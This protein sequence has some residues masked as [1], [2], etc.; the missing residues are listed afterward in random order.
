MVR[1]TIYGNTRDV[2]HYMVI[3]TIYGN[4][5]IYGSITISVETYQTDSMDY[6]V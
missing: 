5:T 4:S 6:Y 3:V 1:D 2:L